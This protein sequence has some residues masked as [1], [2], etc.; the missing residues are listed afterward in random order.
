ME[1]LLL[2][3]VALP[4]KGQLGWGE[5]R[6]RRIEVAIES[7]FEARTDKSSAFTQLVLPL[8]LSLL[9]FG[10]SAVIGSW[11]WAWA[12]AGAEEAAHQTQ[13]GFV[14]LADGR[15]LWVTH[16]PAQPGKPTLVL[17][18]GLTYSVHNWD[19][20]LEFFHQQDPDVGVLRYDMR[21]QGQSLLN[22][23]WVL[24]DI[25]PENQAH[26][27]HQLHQILQIQGPIIHLGLS[28]GGAIA[29]QFEAMYP[30]VTQ[31]VILVAPYLKP[32][33]W[34]DN[35]IR[36]NMDRLRQLNP[37]LPW[38]DRILYKALLSQMVY[39]VYPMAENEFLESPKHF[40]DYM[41]LTRNQ[42]RL[43]GIWRMVNS[44]IDF[45]AVKLLPQLKDKK[46]HLWAPQQDE[47][48]SPE[49]FLHFWGQMPKDL[50]A[51]FMRL[52]GVQHKA[53]QQIP[54]EFSELLLRVIHQDP[55]LRK[56]KEFD[57]YPGPHSCEA[58]LMGSKKKG[59]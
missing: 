29:L 53:Q 23:G 36:E 37:L 19:S 51:S 56:G 47:Y 54:R 40:W 41:A 25:D 11:R 24:Q 48:V 15:K 8:L 20:M 42:L 50:R 16:R 52:Q 28:Y 26:D 44:M 4:F 9:V 49:E 6:M 3:M 59:S 34:Q 14:S 43:N 45:E 18:N 5:S 17:L 39:F 55:Q 38:S 27:L 32:L 10:L 2:S 7:P 35:W 58:V 31:D 21:G 57:F 30:G 12:E 46:Y 22:E 33:E 13:E 1:R